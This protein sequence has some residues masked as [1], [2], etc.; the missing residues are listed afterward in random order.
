M[1]LD[2]DVHVDIGVEDH[3][4]TPR[5]ANEFKFSHGNKSVRVARQPKGLEVA[6]FDAWTPAS[7]SERAIIF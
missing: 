1:N 2:L 3:D 4:A 7:S 6:W 5:I